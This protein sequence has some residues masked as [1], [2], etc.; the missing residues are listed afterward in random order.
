MILLF[1]MDGVKLE[2][3]EKHMPFVSKLNMLPLISEF[4]YS[5]ACHATMY[6]SRYI[7]EHGT[8]F[9]W[10]KGDHSPY[11]W[12]NKVPLLKYLNI[13][14]VKIAVGQVTKRT[15][16]N[17][18]FPGIPMLVNLPLKY[19]GLFET[20]EDRF[21]TDDL[22][23]AEL[24]NL[25]TLLK[26]HGVRNRLIALSKN[27]DPFA[28]ERNVDYKN[29]E[30]VYFFI[31]NTDN[32]MHQYGENGSEIQDYL[33][34]TDNFIK[35]TYEKACRE[36]DDVT[37]ICYSDHG[38]IDVREPKIDINKY[39]RTEGLKVNRYIHLIESTF[40][41]FWFRNAKEEEEIKRVLGNIEEQ[42]LGFVLGRSHFNAYH[43]NFDSN[44]HGDVVFHL[45]APYAFTKTI[46]GFGKTVKSMHGYLP[47]LPKHYGFF[48][49]NRRL[50]EDTAFAALV[51]VLP[52]ILACLKINP[53]QY[54]FHGR[55]IA[56]QELKPVQL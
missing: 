26:K 22:Y 51:D 10:K 44:A 34:K 25:F 37:I 6:T 29:D 48:A 5:C 30:F 42:G 56:A 19:W 18:S 3:A 49:S 24:P 8:W 12:V 53:E 7:D 31:G 13:L 54:V 15:K 33:I 1:F 40:A 28:E 9:V 46:W 41:R 4:G 32:Y 14:P 27:G 35:S 52:T 2:M 16:K 55:N 36:Q 45:N 47:S 38:H 21:W 11:Q 17:S 20:C 39:F 50:S 23:K 43:L